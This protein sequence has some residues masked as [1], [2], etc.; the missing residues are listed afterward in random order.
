MAAFISHQQ[1]SAGEAAE[2]RS[3]GITI[4]AQATMPKVQ[5]ASPPDPT[6]SQGDNAGDQTA[7][8]VHRPDNSS[9]TAANERRFA[10]LTAAKACDQLGREALEEWRLLQIKRRRK[11]S[12]PSAE[13][14]IFQH[15]R[16][17]LESKLVESLQAYV[18]FIQAPRHKKA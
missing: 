14:V 1:G 10:L 15:R 7:L 9:W 5:H 8:I 17:L 2:M 6:M 18:H 3:A 12:P 16:R 4:I 11:L 13:E